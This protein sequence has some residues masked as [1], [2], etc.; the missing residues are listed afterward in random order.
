[1]TRSAAS[2]RRVVGS[3]GGP[4]KCAFVTGTLG[5]DAC[6]DY[7][8]A[9]DAAALGGLLKEAAPAGI[10]M[11][12]ENVGGMHVRAV[13]WPVAMAMMAPFPP[14]LPPVLFACSLMQRSLR[15]GRTGVSQSAARSPVRALLLG[16]V[17]CS[18]P[19]AP[20]LCS[21]QRRGAAPCRRQPLV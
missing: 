16:G 3:A 9:P 8:S 6:I 10:D 14:L 11:Y 4:A 19:H 12:F 15:C 2:L 17:W 13:Q 1:M 21:I 20:S 18:S 7:K 5:F